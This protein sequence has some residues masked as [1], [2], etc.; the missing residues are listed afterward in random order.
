MT[1]Q[2]KLKPKMTT[3]LRTTQKGHSTHVI[4]TQGEYLILK[5]LCKRRLHMKSCTETPR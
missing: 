1:I 5:Y 2:K 4:K 3:T